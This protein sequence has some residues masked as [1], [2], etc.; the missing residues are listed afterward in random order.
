MYVEEFLDGWNMAEANASM[1]Q[2]VE[3]LEQISHARVVERVGAIEQR[4]SRIESAREADE[5]H[6]ATKA[7]IARLQTQLAETREALTAQ[8]LE[9]RAMMVAQDNET[10]A[11][12]TAQDTET[13]AMMVAQDNETRAIMTAQDTETREMMTAQNN[14]TRAMMVAQDNETRAIMTAQDTETREMMTAQNNETREMIMAVSAEAQRER[15]ALKTELKAKISNIIVE[16]EK[17][18]R[19][20]LMWLIGVGLSLAGV[21]I[22][23]AAVIVNQ[24]S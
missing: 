9:T 1:A 10:R 12:M 7:D 24:L 11:I 17:Q 5:Q 2:R 22:A 16:Q 4:V 20:F 15:S 21:V 23:A 6:V 19:K 14:E 3:A 18:F 13:R 8:N